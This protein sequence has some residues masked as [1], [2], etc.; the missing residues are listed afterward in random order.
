MQF[1]AVKSQQL[2]ADPWFQQIAGD[3]RSSRTKIKQIVNAVHDDTV[4][5]HSTLELK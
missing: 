3:R 4:F 5:I 1:S 2:A